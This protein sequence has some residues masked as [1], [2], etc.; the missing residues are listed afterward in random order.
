MPTNRGYSHKAVSPSSSSSC[1]LLIHL[2]QDCLRVLALAKQSSFK[3]RFALR[4]LTWFQGVQG[5]MVSI[6]KLLCHSMVLMEHVLQLLLREASAGGRF[7]KEQGGFSHSCHVSGR[8]FTCASSFQAETRTRREDRRG[9]D[10]QDRRFFFCRNAWWK[11][12]RG[13]DF[14]PHSQPQNSLVRIA[15]CNLVL[16]GNSYQGEAGLGKNCSHCNFQDFHSLS[17]KNQVPPRSWSTNLLR[18]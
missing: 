3:L 15:V 17:K 2:R 11:L 7:M 5:F 9:H 14:D 18:K 16:N 8:S 10:H 4:S 13:S 1:E 12:S 6:D